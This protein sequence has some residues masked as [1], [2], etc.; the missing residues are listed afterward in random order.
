MKILVR[1]WKSKEGFSVRRFRQLRPNFFE[2]FSHKDV[3]IKLRE[4]F[5]NEN[6]RT[7]LKIHG[8]IFSSKVSAASVEK[9]WKKFSHTDVRIKL[10]ENFQNENSR[11]NL[12]IQGWI[13][14]SKISGNFGQI[15]WKILAQGG[16]N[17]GKR[18]F[19]ERKFSHE[20]ENPWKDFQFED[21]WQLRPNFFEK[22]SHTDVR[23]E[24][25][26]V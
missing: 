18:E 11:A 4:N 10:R 16:A 8:R 9:I 5:Q 25:L 1:I 7:N 3:R 23:A 26:C 15:F 20:S 13:F 21:F 19:S 2:K 22:N 14:S 24:A 6:S 17:K 12:K